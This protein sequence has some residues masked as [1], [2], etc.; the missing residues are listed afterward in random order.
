MTGILNIIKIWIVLIII[1]YVNFYFF[2][3]IGPNLF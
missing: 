1:L 2:Y 3:K